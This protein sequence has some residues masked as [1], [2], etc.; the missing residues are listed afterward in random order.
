MTNPNRWAIFFPTIITI[1]FVK[2]PLE[3]FSNEI[4]MKI[5]PDR[6]FPIGSDG[7]AKKSEM[8]GERI[9]RL[10]IN[11]TFVALLYKILL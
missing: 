10:I 6:K 7:R 5:I 2:G 3:R 4:F 1:M 8:L 9:F 11:V